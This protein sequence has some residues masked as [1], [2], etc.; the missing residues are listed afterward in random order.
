MNY[1]RRL[2]AVLTIIIAVLSI[3]GC[4]RNYTVSRDKSEVS[5]TYDKKAAQEEADAIDNAPVLS[6]D[7]MSMWKDIEQKTG[8]RLSYNKDEDSITMESDNMEIVSGGKRIGTIYFTIYDEYP[9]ENDKIKNELVKIIKI[10]SD[11]LGIPYNEAAVVDSL[12]N[13]DHSVYGNSHEVNYCKN[14]DLFSCIWNNGMINCVDF[15]IEP[16]K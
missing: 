14:V 12:T 7:G 4:G 10:M 5:A 2:K 3:S 13:I 8:M 6:V 11:F 1:K 16:K 15:R 9:L